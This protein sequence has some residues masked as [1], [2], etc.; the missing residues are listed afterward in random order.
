MGIK[1]FINE[2]IEDVVYSTGRGVDHYLNRCESPIEKLFAIEL[3]RCEL[4]NN[5]NT[6][7]QPLDDWD[8]GIKWFKPQERVGKYRVDFVICFEK[9]R[10]NIAVAVECDGHDYHERTKEQAQKDK[11]KDRFLQ[12]QGYLIARFTGSEIYQNASDCFWQVVELA[13]AAINR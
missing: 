11:A 12:S 1:Q 13:H 5:F 6:I 3:A 9:N 7:G 2:E 10:K 8:F 4:F